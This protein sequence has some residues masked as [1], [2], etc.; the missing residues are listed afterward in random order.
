MY[1]VY[2]IFP[3]QFNPISYEK[4]NEIIHNLD[5]FK[6]MHVQPVDVFNTKPTHKRL[7]INPLRQSRDPSFKHIFKFH[8]VSR[9]YRSF[10][11][12]ELSKEIYK[13]NVA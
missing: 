4:N 8:L 1:D 5:R 3:F 9:N 10:I 11:I 6:E 13:R 7:G 12:R 2:I